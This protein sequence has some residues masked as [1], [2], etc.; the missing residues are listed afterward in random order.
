MIGGRTAKGIHGDFKFTFKFPPVRRLDLLLQLCLLIDEFFHLIGARVA[1]AVADRFVFVQQG[2]QF[3][4]AFLHDF[5][6]GFVRI[7]LRLL[8]KQA[9]AIAL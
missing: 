5:F 8:L 4:L 7:E 6:D 1:H 9:D 3:F 2:D